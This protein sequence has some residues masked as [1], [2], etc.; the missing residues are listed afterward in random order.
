MLSTF[1]LR[2]A[3]LAL[4]AAAAPAAAQNSQI[5]LDGSLFHGRTDVLTGP[6]TGPD[7]TISEEFGERRGANLFHS[8]RDFSIA[9]G[10]SATFTAEPGSASLSNVIARVTGGQPSEIN[11]RLAV[12]RATIPSADFYLLNPRGV[13]F[14]GASSIDVPASFTAST[15]HQLVFSDATLDLVN[16]ASAPLLSSQPPEAFGFMSG[17][18]RAP[19]VF[20]NPLPESGTRDYAVAAGET[21]SILAGDVRVENNTVLRAPS[22]R[23]QLAAVGNSAA[24]RIPLDFAAPLETFGAAAALGAVEVRTGAQLLASNANRALGQG[25]VVVRGGRFVLASGPVAGVEMGSVVRAGDFAG[26]GGPSIDVAVSGHVDIAGNNTFV[27]S[28]AQPTRPSGGVRILADTIEV[29]DGAFVQTRSDAA[30]GIA[31]GDLVLAA[32]EIRLT[33]GGI[34]SSLTTRQ[35]AGGNV[36]LSADLV[37]VDG[38]EVQS[39]AGAPGPGGDIRINAD[40]LRVLHGAIGAESSATGPGGDIEIDADRVEV[41][42][43]LSQINTLN[44]IAAAPE[45]TIPGG[46]IRIGGEAD[47]ASSVIVA[48]GG[49]VSTETSGAQ[50]GGEI[51]VFADSLDVTGGDVDAQGDPRP[52]ALQTSTVS[53]A[54]TGVGGSIFLELGSLRVGADEPG[55]VPGIVAAFV[56]EDARS[57]GGSIE[58]DGVSALVE[59]GG[60]IFTTTSGIGKAGSIDVDLTGD[61]VARGSRL[62]GGFKPSGLFAR[63]ETGSSG[64]AGNIRVVARSIEVL[65]AGGI[66]SRADGSGNSGNIALL[67]TDAIRIVGGFQAS[68]VTARG[69]VGRAGNVT[70]AGPEKQDGEIGSVGIVELLDGGIV[71]VSTSGGSE[72][73]LVRVV[74]DEL[75]ISGTSGTGIPS[76]L[77]A[78]T[79]GAGDAL[80]ID[81]D[82]AGLVR[83]ERDGEINSRTVGAGR[84]GDIHVDAAVIEFIAGDGTAESEAGNAGAGSMSLEATKVIR[85]FDGARLVVR[86]AEGQDAG[87]LRLFA[88]RIEIRDS[89]L[90]A[91]ASA[92][93]G[94][95]E[96]TTDSLLLEKSSIVAFS[97]GETAGGPDALAI[98]P[99]G[100]ETPAG[101]NITIEG[102]AVILNESVLNANGFGNANGGFID[103]TADPWLRSGDSAITAS[104][105]FGLD[106]FVLVNTPYGEVTGDLA[107]LPE[108]FLDASSLLEEPCLA[109]DAPSGSFAVQRAARVPPPPDAPLS[110]APAEPQQCEAPPAP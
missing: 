73:G 93:G 61:F 36:R 31:S 71:D 23:V 46:S 110:A 98:T 108:T 12:D 24:Q 7:Y 34:A 21:F 15:A 30:A 72:G 74:A 29:R 87:T 64:D 75:R 102:G 92:F 40:S 99:G 77:G 37:E 107:A 47:R 65:D 62:E 26:Q 43:A 96:I 86:S 69:L 95:V 97:R 84:A 80:G 20:S 14:G 104:S 48:D 63:G 100:V 33:D 32:R 81:V 83:V 101:G 66:S 50:P 11:G 28:E 89:A 41:R 103:I 5:S 106:G 49:V 54:E 78:E 44:Q 17:G 58:I 38:G 35:G 109:R 13:L 105:E 94:N 52:S 39:F 22:G 91:D 9:T 25:S 67:A 57:P 27:R 6:D 82:V 56:A 90:T 51:R 76:S 68:S 85:V 55:G 3:V 59:D 19:V 4:L 45:P 10:E 53:V 16:T 88:P 42:G 1:R 2:A 70:L 79:T 60:Q 8:F 18:P